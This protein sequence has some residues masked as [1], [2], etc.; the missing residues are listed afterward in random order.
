MVSKPSSGPKDES[1]PEKTSVIQGRLLALIAGNA[2]NPA[3]EVAQ[4]FGVS[5]QAV[6]AH[7][8]KLVSDGWIQATGST[9][10][11][12]Y[13]LIEKSEEKVFRIEEG[14]SEDD[15]WEKFVVPVLNHGEIAKN[16]LDICQYG[17]TEIVNNA[18]DH[19]ESRFVVVKVN[20]G[21]YRVQII[22]ADL[23]IGIFKKIKEACGLEN[24]HHAILEL[25]KGKLT[26]DP[27]KHTGEG[28]YFSSKMFDEFVILSRGIA[29]THIGGRSGSGQKDKEMVMDI[30]MEKAEGTMVRMTVSPRTKR[31]RLS[32]FDAYSSPQDNTFSSTYVPV[33][34]AKAGDSNLISRSQSKRMTARFELFSHVALDFSGVTSV[35]QAFMDE[36]FRVFVLQ[37]P[38]VKLR[39]MGAGDEVKKMIARILSQP[40]SSISSSGEVPDPPQADSKTP[41]IS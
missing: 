34:L 39:W 36:T 16:A 4:W 19:S 7:L 41:S 1:E 25:A 3:G 2:D 24:E 32:V 17:L 12:R 31:T 5:R 40:I 21:K 23:G 37:H 10:S 20:C 13:Q 15:V 11:R 9:R 22:V 28:I 29:Y 38:G 26:T 6:N 27:S 14:L 8:R 30:S 35:G 33:E 18:I